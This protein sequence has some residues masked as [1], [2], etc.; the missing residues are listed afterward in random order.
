MKF[1][2]PKFSNFPL[3]NCSRI[4]KTC[5]TFHCGYSA[6]QMREYFFMAWFWPLFF[7]FFL[8]LAFLPNWMYIS[9]KTGIIFNYLNVFLP[10][11][12]KIPKITVIFYFLFTFRIFCWISRNCRNLRFFN[13]KWDTIHIFLWSLLAVM[14]LLCISLH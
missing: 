4:F 1:I 2:L 3:G 6:H 8:L 7:I 5:F 11:Y 14:T 12:Q 13:K 10:R 9:S